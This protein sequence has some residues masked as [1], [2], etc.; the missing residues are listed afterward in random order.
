MLPLWVI[1]GTPCVSDPG[2]EIIK[3]ARMQNIELEIIPGVSA[4]ITGFVGAAFSNTFSFLGF[5]K[6]K[7]EQRKKNLNNKL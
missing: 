2:F 3:L 7:S 5:V 4:V 6:D 1:L